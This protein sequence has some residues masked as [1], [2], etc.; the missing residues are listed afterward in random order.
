MHRDNLKNYDFVM[1][2]MVNERQAEWAQMCAEER[3]PFGILSM[4][5]PFSALPFTDDAHFIA[6]CFSP[7]SPE[8]EA[9][10]ECVFRTGEFRGTF[11]YQQ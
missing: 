6:I 8:V 5:D 9:L 10:F 3:I 2:G 7:Y 11:P 4:Q 1:I